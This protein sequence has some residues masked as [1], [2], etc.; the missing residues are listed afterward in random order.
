M[1]V[2]VYNPHVIVLPE[3]DADRQIANGFLLDPSIKLRNI[4]VLSPAGGWGKVLDSFLNDHVAEL[5][6]WPQRHLVLLID[7]DDH[8]EDRTKMFVEKFPPEVQDR[9]FLLGTRGEPEELRKQC[10]N[11]LENVGKALA[12]EC[13]YDETTLWNHKL[14]AH[15]AA[16]RK[17]LND[18]VKAILFRPR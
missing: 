1:S 4:Q 3:D 7:F 15:N 14:L 9:V 17:R 8:V 18:K 12:S 16:D 11:S 2:D 5:K 6:K 10:G 13:Y